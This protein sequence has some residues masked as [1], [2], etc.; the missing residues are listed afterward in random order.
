[1]QFWAADRQADKEIHCIHFGKLVQ[2]LFY[3]VDCK[4]GCRHLRYITWDTAKRL[5]QENKLKCLICNPEKGLTSLEQTVLDVLTTLFP[6]VE[7]FPQCRALS[8]FPGPIDFCLLFER[9][10]IQVDGDSHSGLLRKPNAQEADQPRIDADCN[11]RATEQGWHMLRIHKDDVDECAHVIQDVL[12]VAKAARL[13][14][15]GHRD[16]MMSSVTWSEAFGRQREVYIVEE[17]K[18]RQLTS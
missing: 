7:V 10:L 17:G 6:N 14:L 13:A 1:M 18:V 16:C 9:V 11:T 4:G 5:V 2:D 15:Q 3:C 12:I 8:K